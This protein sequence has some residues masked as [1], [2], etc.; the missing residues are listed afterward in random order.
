MHSDCGPDRGPD[1]SPL[2]KEIRHFLN[3]L[4][5][6]H[7]YNNYSYNYTYSSVIYLYLRLKLHSLSLSLSLSLSHSRLLLSYLRALPTTTPISPTAHPYPLTT[8][9]TLIYRTKLPLSPTTS[10]HLQQSQIREIEYHQTDRQSNP[11][12]QFPL[13]I[14][15]LY[16]VVP[17]PLSIINHLLSVIKTVSIRV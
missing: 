9:T 15:Q 1:C 13:P 11:S 4:T 2:Y 8:T 10:T 14:F 6:H 16:L 5:I 3:F 7:T 12:I 17:G